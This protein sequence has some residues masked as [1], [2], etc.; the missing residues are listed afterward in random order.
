MHDDVSDCDVFI[1]FKDAVD[2]A[3]ILYS[4]GGKASVLAPDWDTVYADFTKALAYLRVTA[5]TPSVVPALSKEGKK[6]FAK[7][8]QEFDKVYTSLKSFIRYADNPPESY[9][10]TQAE[11]DDYAAHYLN[12]IQELKPDPGPDPGPEPGPEPPIDFE[13]ELKA[14]S[15][16]K[17]D[18]DYIVSLIQ[19]VVSATD[20][21]RQEQH[22]QN[23]VIEITKYIEEL[24]S[25]N[26][27]LG[28]LM[29]QLWEKVQENPDEFKGKRVSYVLAEMRKEAID[30][31]LRG[32]AE[33]W[34]VSLDAVSY[35]ADRYQVGDTDLPGLNNLKKSADFDSYS[36]KHEGISKFKY[37][38]SV[39]KA[40]LTLLNEDV[41]PLRDDDYRI[42]DTALLNKS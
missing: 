26:P 8:F 27:K 38:Q 39:K 10:I 9:G 32:F 29:Q 25:S 5:E 22:Y 31:V 2:E 35:A 20:E 13:Y 6:R 41:I 18:Y 23:L 30:S 12:V 24:L 15:K 21:E 19:S 40:L 4:A 17:I 11:Y 3:L 34:C 33:E 7:A 1:V 37:H 16:E 14:Y 42:D 36:A 28:A